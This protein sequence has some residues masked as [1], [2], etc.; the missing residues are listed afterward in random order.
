[1]VVVAAEVL[2]VISQQVTVVAAGGLAYKVQSPG[3]P[4]G[5]DPVAVVV[6]VWYH[7]A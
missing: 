4:C 7:Q 5:M 1:V 6:L 3:L 2:V